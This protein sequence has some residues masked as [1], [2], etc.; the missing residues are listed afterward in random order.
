MKASQ[1]EKSS[2]SMPTLVYYGKEEIPKKIFPLSVRGE[3]DVFLSRGG[4]EW[5]CCI[6]SGCTVA[7]GVLNWSYKTR[8]MV[9]DLLLENCVTFHKALPL[10]SPGISSVKY[11]KK[12]LGILNS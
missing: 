2:C 11:G 7:E 9:L 1:L 6:S 3:A 4:R 12:A 5:N 10:P 8:F